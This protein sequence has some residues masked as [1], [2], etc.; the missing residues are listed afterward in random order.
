MQADYMARLSPVVQQF[1]RHV[2]DVSGVSIDVCLDPELNKRGPFGN[3]ML[4]VEIYSNRVILH[5]P[6][7]EYFPDGA[8]FHELLHISRFH[9]DGVPHLTL[10][11]DEAR[12]PSLERSLTTIDNDIEHL[13]IVP[14]ELR[15]HPE[16]LD[17]WE[18]NVQGLWFR[19]IPSINCP[20]N[21]RIETFM[22]WAFIKHVLP[23]SP[24]RHVAISFMKTHGLMDE[25]EDFSQFMID[26]LDDKLAVIKM[27]FDTFPELPRNSA[28]VEYLNLYTGSTVQPIPG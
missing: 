10:A 5:A 22:N 12:N 13:V 17:H 28:G 8:V 20:M 9:L 11:E 18:T 4:K 1:A 19:E 16:R 3:G 23:S 2:E 6:T 7:N 21:R 27:F 15:A 24:T 25:A 26:H 14:I